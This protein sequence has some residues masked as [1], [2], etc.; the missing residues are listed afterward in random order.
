M[1][2]G[3]LGPLEVADNGR[4]PV[5]APGKQRAL[6]AILLLQANEVVSSD[7]LV[8]ALWGEQPPASAAK[9]LQVHVSRLRKALGGPEGP[10]TTAPNGYSIRVAP[11]EL[12]LERFTR[13]AEEGRLALGADD[14]ERG[15]ELLREALSLWRGPP[16]ADFTFEPFAQL[17]IGGLEELRLAALED[18]IDADLARGRHAELVGE[19]EALVAAHPLRE[20]LRRQV[21]LALYRVGR[22]ADALEAYRAARAKLM[23]ELGL[24]PTPELRQLEQAILTHDA[25][26]HAPA[27]AAARSS[28]LPAPATRTIGR[29]DDREAVSSLLCQDGIRLVT[30]TGPGGVGKTRLALEFARALEPELPDGAWFI[31]LAATARAEH[32]ARTIAQA[33]RVTPLEARAHNRPSSVSCHRSAACSC[34]TTSSICWPRRH[35]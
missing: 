30:L 28:R 11:G 23:D 29:D 14:P 9:S 1:D 5:I 25:A 16:V 10:I 6:L 20:R 13:L 22:Q 34:S 27:A 4:E 35:S 17:E 26:V 18:R 33:I 3:I 8:E 15:A 24:E 31:S 2:F 7:R 19:L 12:D 32:V 21:V